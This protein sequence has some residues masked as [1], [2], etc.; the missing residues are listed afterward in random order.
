[1]TVADRAWSAPIPPRAATLAVARGGVL[2]GVACDRDPGRLAAE[3]SYL[4]YTVANGDVL[5]G[6]APLP[7]G[8]GGDRH[9]GRPR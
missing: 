2:V 7:G 6:W 4:R 5:L 8:H 9:P 1:V 3:A